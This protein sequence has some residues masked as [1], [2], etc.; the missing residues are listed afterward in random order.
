MAAMTGLKVKQTNFGAKPSILSLEKA[1]LKRSVFLFA[2]IMQRLASAGD[3]LQ[4]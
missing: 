4:C 2:E 1:A 3:S